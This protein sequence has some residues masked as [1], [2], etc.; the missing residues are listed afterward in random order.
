[1][2]NNTV[3]SLMWQTL[4]RWYVNTSHVG[5]TGSRMPWLRGGGQELNGRD[6]TALIKTT[7]GSVK[8]RTRAVSPHSGRLWGTGVK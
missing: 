7:G 2:D 3:C 8:V 4:P 6:S 5:R 1:M